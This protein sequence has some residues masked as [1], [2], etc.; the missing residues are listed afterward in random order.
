MKAR[1][2]QIKLFA[3]NPGDV[4]PTSLV[5]VFHEWIKK[6]SLP[7]LLIDVVDYQHVDQGPSVLLVG[8]ESDYAVDFG[9]GAAGLLYSRKRSGPSDEEALVVDALGKAL[10]ACRLIEEDGS[11]S[12]RIAFDTGRVEFRLNDRLLAPHSQATFD[13]AEPVFERALARVYGGARP[14]IR[15]VEG[16]PRDLPTLEARF[17]DPPSVADLLARVS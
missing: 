11:L 3:K 7:E 17:V 8:H 16:D 13:A 9:G 4:S 6:G 14:A 5:P 12:P 2:L 10:L 15:R 1:K